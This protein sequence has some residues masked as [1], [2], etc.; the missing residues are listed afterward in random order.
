MVTTALVVAKPSGSTAGT[1][2]PVVDGPVAVV[3]VASLVLGDGV[4]VGAGAVVGSVAVA[5]AGAVV[6]SVGVA[7]SA[8]E[9]AP[10]AQA[11]A[12][13]TSHHADRIPAGYDDATAT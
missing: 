5:A 12:S 11:V 2:G 9:P 10:D 13:R 1:V 3:S 6:G 4:V 8:V 7:G